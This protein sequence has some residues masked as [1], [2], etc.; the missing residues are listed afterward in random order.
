MPSPASFQ[1]FSSSILPSQE[2]EVLIA[3][4][5]ALANH[6]QQTRIALNKLPPSIVDTLVGD[7]KAPTNEA[8]G[9]VFVAMAEREHVIESAEQG[10]NL[11]VQWLQE[12]ASSQK[13]MN[14][15]G[16]GQNDPWNEAPSI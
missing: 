8:L 7:Y 15:L 1:S 10:R 6:G 3:K 9:V 14:E 5:S 2:R 16:L 4:Q 11:D 12:G 13:N